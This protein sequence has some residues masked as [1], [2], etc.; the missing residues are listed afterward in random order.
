MHQPL[1]R[2]SHVS[3][4]GVREDQEAWLTLRG[5]NLR[6]ARVAMVTNRPLVS[7]REVRDDSLRVYFNPQELNLA[8]GRY[9][10]RV[11]N[12]WGRGEML[13]DAIE[14]KLSPANLAAAAL[15]SMQQAIDATEGLSPDLVL[16]LHA[17]QTAIE[18]A[19]ARP[20]SVEAIYSIQ[21]SL[22]TAITTIPKAQGKLYSLQATIEA[23]L[24]LPDPMPALRSIRDAITNKLAEAGK[25]SDDVRAA[26]LSATLQRRSKAGT[27]SDSSMD[28]QSEVTLHQLPEAW[29]TVEGRVNLGRDSSH[30]IRQGDVERDA[31]GNVVAKVLWAAIESQREATRLYAVDAGQVV[32]VAPSRQQ[33]R[34]RLLLKLRAR[35]RSGVYYYQD[36]PL[37]VARRIVLTTGRRSADVELVGSARP[38][39]ETATWWEGVEVD[40]LVKRSDGRDGIV[41]A[42]RLQ[43]GDSIL[44]TRGEPVGYVAQRFLQ[45]SSDDQEADVLMRVRMRIKVSQDAV[46]I[47]TAKSPQLERLARGRKLVFGTKDGIFFGYVLNEIAVR[48]TS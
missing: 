14:V 13:A 18:A 31:S 9:D 22:E 43:P 40:L 10:M 34:L 38:V 1:P 3:P 32:T 27:Q 19:L 24:A 45:P 29:V 39:P 30:L 8:A 23:A 16:A 36:L 26:V 2:I 33:K 41:V 4:S 42:N 25:A 6:Y 21:D 15:Q 37:I 46:W 35:E 28:S 12:G 5:S 20:N 47:E 7:L 48:D 17:I 11:L 44:N